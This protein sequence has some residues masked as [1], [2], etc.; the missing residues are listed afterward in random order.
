[1]LNSVA[2]DYVAEYVNLHKSCFRPRLVIPTQ[3][4]GDVGTLPTSWILSIILTCLFAIIL[5]PFVSESSF[6]VSLILPLKLHCSVLERLGHLVKHTSWNTSVIS[7]SLSKYNVS[8]LV[9]IIRYRYTIICKIS[10]NG[11]FETSAKL[12]GHPVGKAFL[13][14]SRSLYLSISLFYWIEF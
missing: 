10:K 11:S 9:Y 3:N 13:T 5:I 1:M 8:I 4:V 7:C 14:H 2:I 12:L 6:Y